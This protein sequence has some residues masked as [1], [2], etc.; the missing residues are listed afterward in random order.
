MNS[1]IMSF[2]KIKVRNTQIAKS[3]FSNKRKKQGKN[4]QKITQ[5]LKII[6]FNN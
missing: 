3:N 5:L 1:V 6:T 4:T 2:I